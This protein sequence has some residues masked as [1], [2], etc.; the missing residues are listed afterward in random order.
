M[1]RRIFR[2]SQCFGGKCKVRRTVRTGRG[3]NKRL[4]LASTAAVAVATAL[5][6]LAP[7]SAA[8]TTGVAIKNVNSGLVLDVSGG[9]T[10]NNA[11]VI[12]WAD[13]GGTNQ[14][15]Q[16]NAVSG[17][18]FTFA[19]DNSK[20]CLDVKSASTSAGASLVQNTCSGTD[21]QLW[22]VTTSNG[23]SSIT[24]KRSGLAVDVYGGSSSQGASI[25]QYAFDGGTNQL[26]VITGSG[27]G[28][29]TTTVPKT[30]TTVP[31]STTTVPKSTTTVPKT[32]TTSTTTPN[33][34]GADSSKWALKFSDDFN[35]NAAEGKFLSTYTNFVGYDDGSPDTSR[36][37]VRDNSILSV[38]NGV[39]NYHLS[40][41]SSGIGRTAVV[42][43]LINGGTRTEWNTGQLY[44]RYEVRF[45]TDKGSDGYTAA[46]L[47]W[48]ASNNWNE[49]EI[50][51]PEG[52]LSGTINAF[53][54]CVGNPESNCLAAGSNATYT[55]W[56]TAV[57]E[58]T[59]GQVKFILD[60]TV[61]GTSNVAPKVP[62]QMSLQTDTAYGA[63][64]T[65]ADDVNLSVDYV[66]VWS[67]KG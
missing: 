1:G 47:L 3:V 40:L 9:S 59:P 37:G 55:S 19:N 28:S 41:N 44:G 8:T 2:R 64:P 26:F 20:K 57:T 18:Y 33:N 66:K 36:I 52:T 32:T 11:P 22:K 43:P 30:T 50:D 67:Y 53:N 16:Q 56:H 12:Q 31:K 54:H 23:S 65:K 17:G 13:D 60:G 63:V 10:A 42:V 7:V 4:I 39:L 6:H 49:G 34:G 35:T 27:S 61:L 48:P 45:K 25:I 24:N 14:R 58:W 46:F 51:F 5:V 21:S 15:W 29:T 62:M 38:S